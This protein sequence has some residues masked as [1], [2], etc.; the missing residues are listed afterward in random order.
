MKKIIF[1]SHNKNK[2]KEINKIFKQ[3]GIEILSLNNF[4][5]IKEVEECGS[6]FEENARIKS[7][8]GF[9]NFKLPCFADDSGLCIKAFGNLPGIRSKRF[10]EESGSIEKAF[11]IIIDK[12]NKFS[13][14]NAYFKTTISLT[15]NQNKTIFFDGIIKG[16]ISL[17][18][19]GL[20]GFHYDPIFIPD[21]YDKTF[22][23]M[24]LK[25]KNKIS[26]RAIASQKLKKY[27]LKLVN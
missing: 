18:P 21:G 24:N 13:D 14:R 10:I 12:T 20:Y 6:S 11:K 1:Y 27:L 5:N 15:Y 8:Y 7:S 23:Q 4:P 22:A 16:R 2:I 19:K 3:S 26:H 25:E 17:E 9:K